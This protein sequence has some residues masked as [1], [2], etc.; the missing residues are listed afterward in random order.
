MTRVHKPCHEN[1]SSANDLQDTHV[2]T[3]LEKSLHLKASVWSKTSLDTGSV[4]GEGV[5]PPLMPLH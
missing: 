3:V 1:R 4:A 5:D 2:G